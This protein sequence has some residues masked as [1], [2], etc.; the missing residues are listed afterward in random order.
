MKRC[1]LLPNSVCVRVCVHVPGWVV[2]SVGGWMGVRKRENLFF[3]L[4]LKRIVYELRSYSP[5]TVKV[6]CKY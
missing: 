1:K 5:V 4:M 6:I 3:V 2:G